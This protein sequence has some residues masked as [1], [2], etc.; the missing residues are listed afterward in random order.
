[1][2]LFLALA[3]AVAV[4]APA[5]T[6]AAA[7]AKTAAPKAAAAPP[8]AVN[9]AQPTPV[10]ERVAELMALDKRTG[11]SQGFA[12]K[13]GQQLAFG[14]LLIRMRACETTPEWEQKQ[15]AAFLQIDEVTSATAR[16][17]VYS[18]WMFAESPS[19]NPLQNPRYDVWVKSCTMSFPAT[20][21]DTVVA[22]R[23]GPGDKTSG[24]P[25]RASS[26]PKSPAPATADA[27]SPR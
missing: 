24:D 8:A 2:S 26:A 27:N 1:M 15:T 7:P 22:S 19:L 3:A 21:P 11:K 25:K 16:K 18:G 5:A 17:R 9:V 12:I 6:P 20:G 14:S 23:A 13:A 4:S 10:N